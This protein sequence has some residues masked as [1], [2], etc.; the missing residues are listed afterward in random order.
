ME[1]DVKNRAVSGSEFTL[2]IPLPDVKV[3]AQK[4]KGSK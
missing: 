3:A 4:R 1:I 2:S